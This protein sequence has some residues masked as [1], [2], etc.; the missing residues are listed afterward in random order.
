MRDG[1]ASFIIESVKNLDL[2][3]ISIKEGE[4]APP[5]FAVQAHHCYCSN[6]FLPAA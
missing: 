3:G 5:S 1:S 6:Y 2:L 4:Q